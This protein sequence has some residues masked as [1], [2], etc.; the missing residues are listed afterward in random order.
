[1]F[2]EVWLFSEILSLIEDRYSVTFISFG[3][4]D[5]SIW[6]IPVEEIISNIESATTLNKETINVD[7]Q[8]IW[9]LVSNALREGL[10]KKKHINYNLTKDEMKVLTDFKN[11]IDYIIKSLNLLKDKKA[12]VKLIS[13]L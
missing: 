9:S 4:Y 12:Y 3:N 1:M 5:V 10:S 13:M 7:P 2:Q 8:D 11:E 6:K